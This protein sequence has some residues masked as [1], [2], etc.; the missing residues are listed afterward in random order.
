MGHVN[1]MVLLMQ[2]KQKEQAASQQNIAQLQQE[3][4]VQAAQQRAAKETQQ[5]IGIP[6]Q[7]SQQQQLSHPSFG[8]PMQPHPPNQARPSYPMVQNQGT[9]AGAGGGG[10]ITVEG[11]HSILG[12]TNYRK[13][14]WATVSK[15]SLV[16][17]SVLS[18]I[19]FV[20]GK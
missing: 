8:A 1:P 14:E 12:E 19:L 11:I 4:M 3:A 5:A 15:F 17:V 6:Q 18:L 7:Q 9:G 13:G 16:N 20:L 2:A 10:E